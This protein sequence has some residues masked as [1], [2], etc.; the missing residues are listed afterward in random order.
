MRGVMDQRAFV[1]RLDL[2][3]VVAVAGIEAGDLGGRQRHL[4]CGRGLA[5]NRQIR[6]AARALQ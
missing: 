6:Q 5:R 2:A 3:V 1:E 4:P